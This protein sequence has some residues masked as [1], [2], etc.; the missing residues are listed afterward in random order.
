MKDN[1]Y[2]YSKYL[3]HNQ[4]TRWAT[5]EEI[6][7]SGTYVEFGKEGSAA[8]LPLLSNGRVGYVDD[9]DTHTLIFGS[10]GSK[11]T[12]LFGMP[13]L[14]FFAAAGES[15]IA[16]DP[17]GELYMKTAGYVKSQGYNIV[18]INFRD[19]AKGDMWNP[20]YLPYKLYREGKV[21]EATAML[22]DFV[23]T[24]AE[25]ILKNTKD[26]YWGEAASSYALGALLLIMECAR[27]EEAH[28]AS[29]ASLCGRDYEDILRD[30]VDNMSD[31]ALCAINLKGVLACPENTLR[32]IY[33]TLFS[34]V[35]IFV[36]Q[37][38]LSA[39]LAG[40]TIDMTTIGKQKTAVYIIVPDEKTTYHFLVT[41]FIKQ[42]YET[43]I[44]EAQNSPDKRLPVRVNLVLDEFCNIPRI[45]DMPSMISAARSRNMR[46]YLIVQSYHQ[47]RGKYGED[48]DT[49]KGNC[50]NWVF[51]TSK[52]LSLLQEISALCGT[53]HLKGEGDRKLIS[54]S[55][56]QRLSKE[57]GE[58]LIMHARQY[59]IITEIADVDAYGAFAGYTAPEEPDVR[60]A[61][62]RIFD[63]KEM[64]RRISTCRCVYPFSKKWE[65]AKYE[66]DEIV[67]LPEL[68]SVE[69]AE[70]RAGFAPASDGGAETFTPPSSAARIPTPPPVS[71]EA[72]KDIRS[73]VEA[74]R[75][76]MEELKR[77]G[78]AGQSKSAYVPKPVDTEDVVLPE[79]IAELTEQLAKN[80]HE[81]W[82][83][84][85]LEQGWSFGEKRDDEKR[86]HPCLV[87]YEALPESEKEFDRNTAM[88]T[89]KL[90]I[91]LGYRIEKK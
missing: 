47:L 61:R 19:L 16:T 34:M 23:N 20:L 44:A 50:D 75:K 64:H 3:N 73:R 38:N 59:P 42:V 8:G 6:E 90:I 54:E 83:R 43:L 48:A 40:N 63:I 24:V 66:G 29:L 18:T 57:K 70:A 5:R 71:S 58:A 67:Y 36:A 32:C 37:K 15:F 12:R 14:N 77:R 27:P 91:K 35:R 51:L 84:T 22:N 31:D 87:D 74:L 81:V 85:R 62:A 69:D 1:G 88:Q 60:F 68:E 17:K 78:E 82:S 39:K 26:A 2:I 89:L 11:K 33:S 55:E 53:N 72:V 45:P 25:P 10:T 28:P 13:L 4:E 76:R 79:S 80:T 86:L 30:L 49:I 21:D 46:F 9:K 7:A 56:L 65:E 52:E 41:T